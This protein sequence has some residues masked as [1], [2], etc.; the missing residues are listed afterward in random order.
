MFV[1][2]FACSSLLEGSSGAD[3]NAFSVN[4]EGSFLAAKAFVNIADNASFSSAF[5]AFSTS[6]KG[7][8]RADGN[9]LV[10]KKE[11]SLIAGLALVGYGAS[12]AVSRAGLA[13]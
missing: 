1:A 9:A 5:G 11:V 8:K 7:S 6:S 10:V 13:N 2:I 4:E 12:G 3:S